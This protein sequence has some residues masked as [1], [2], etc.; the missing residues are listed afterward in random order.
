MYVESSSSARWLAR[1]Q[2]LMCLCAAGCMSRAHADGG[3]QPDAAAR[4]RLHAFGPYG[5]RLASSL[6]Y[7][8]GIVRL[9][10]RRTRPVERRPEMCACPAGAPSE[11]ALNTARVAATRGRPQLPA[12][13][14]G[15]ASHPP[16][17]R[18]MP[19]VESRTCPPAGEREGVACGAPRSV[20]AN[21]TD[22]PGESLGAAPPTQVGPRREPGG[23]GPS[24]TRISKLQPQVTP[25]QS[26][27]LPSS[28][29]TLP[30]L[31]WMPG[32]AATPPRVRRARHRCSICSPPPIA[33]V[34]RRRRRVAGRSRWSRRART[35]AVSHGGLRRRCVAAVG[36]AVARRSGARTPAAPGACALSYRSAGT[37]LQ[38]G[39][40]R[41]GTIR[42][43][44]R[45][46]R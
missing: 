46:R 34:H 10:A 43:H 23:R 13:S 32:A 40:A 41:R 33:A 22:R 30:P 26:S 9:C 17:P 24:R 42:M 8:I 3:D 14:R 18:A 1:A 37:E 44:L 28:P 31:G 5:S 27:N 4:D 12:A 45:R 7:A 11:C 35:P 21:D 19:A 6:R 36:G 25:P 20:P 15:G 2:L 38:S 16:D 29:S 39:V